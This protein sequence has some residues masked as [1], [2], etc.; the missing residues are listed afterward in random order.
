M[1]GPDYLSVTMNFASG[2]E[3]WGSG[4]LFLAVQAGAARIPYGITAH[5]G[6]EP[7][8]QGA[9]RAPDEARPQG[10]F[11]CVTVSLPL[12]RSATNCTF[13]PSFSLASNASSP[14]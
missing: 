7:V 4:R 6:V 14:T 12:T 8:F 13:A 1:K 9:G 5:R 11:T 3:E 10:H 2:S